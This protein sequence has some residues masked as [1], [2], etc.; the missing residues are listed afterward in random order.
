MVPCMHRLHLQRIAGAVVVG[1][2]ALAP[3]IPAT[4]G[5]S[6]DAQAFMNSLPSGGRAKTCDK[7]VTVRVNSDTAEHVKIRFLNQ[8]YKP[9]KDRYVT[10]RGYTVI[11]S[12]KPNR[13]TTIKHVVFGGCGFGKGRYRVVAK[14]K[15]YYTEMMDCGCGME[16]VVVGR[17]SV[18]RAYGVT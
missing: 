13:W 11:E 2:L 9:K 12:I 1:L 5:S 14:A 17:D 18:K 16:T 8:K 15:A 10:M 7:P 3:A 6:G 4:A